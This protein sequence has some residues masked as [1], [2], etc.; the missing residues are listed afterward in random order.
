MTSSCQEQGSWIF[1]YTRI[2]GSDI[3]VIQTREVWMD[4][5]SQTGMV[6]HSPFIHFLRFQMWNGAFFVSSDVL[7]KIHSWADALLG[8]RSMFFKRI[9]EE[10]QLKRETTPTWH[11]PVTL[12]VVVLVWTFLLLWVFQ[13]FIVQG[14]I[15]GII[16]TPHVH[17]NGQ[18]EISF[19]SQRPCFSVYSIFYLLLLTF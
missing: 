16:Q 15:T 2:S 6:I 18:S 12:F 17:E 8:K 13:T 4:G 7:H 3:R 1:T 14:K 19:L 5:I 9:G 10:Q 11:N